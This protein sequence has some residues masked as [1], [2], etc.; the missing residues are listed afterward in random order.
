MI[1]AFPDPIF[2]KDLQHRWIA[3]NSAH[4]T[5]MGRSYIDITGV[6]IIDTS[7]AS[8]LIRAF[9][10][11]QLLGCQSI[12]VGISPEIAQTLVGLGVDFS[13]IIT[14][15]TLQNGLEYGLK[16]LNYDVTRRR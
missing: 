7:V 3:C 14:R 6:P 11:T 4:C 12:L 2:V 5:L 15:A 13:R 8:Y 1:D 16:R 10:A 9:Q